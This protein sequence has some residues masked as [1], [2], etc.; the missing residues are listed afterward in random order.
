MKA[1]ESHKVDTLFSSLIIFKQQIKYFSLQTSKPSVRTWKLISKGAW[2][3]DNEDFDDIS[4]K[5]TKVEKMD[6]RNESEELPEE[7]AD[8]SSID[9]VIEELIKEGVHLHQWIGVEF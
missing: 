8:L 6:R 2:N 9:K 3:S 1:Q 4:T 5:T 7:D